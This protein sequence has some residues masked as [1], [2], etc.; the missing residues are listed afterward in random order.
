VFATI[1]ICWLWVNADGSTKYLL[2]DLTRLDSIAIAALRGGRELVIR[3]AVFRL[4]DRK[5]IDF[6]GEGRDAEIT[7][8]KQYPQQ[9][10]ISRG[11]HVEHITITSRSPL[12]QGGHQYDFKG[13][14]VF[15]K[16]ISFSWSYFINIFGLFSFIS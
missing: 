11:E 7:T 14:H 13:Y 6:T 5:F 4:W 2:P 1:A 8:R 16:V 12:M 15:S 3:T 9:K 10:P